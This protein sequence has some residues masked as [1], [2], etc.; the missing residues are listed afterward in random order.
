MIKKK[1]EWDDF[2]PN[3]DPDTTINDG[4]RRVTKSSYSKYF[5]K[6]CLFNLITQSSIYIPKATDSMKFL[7]E[8]TSFSSCSSTE[9]GGCILYDGLK[10][11]FSQNKI[12]SYKAEAPKDGVY[13]LVYHSML[14]KN[15]IFDSSISYSGY[16]SNIGDFNLCFRG[17]SNISNINISKSK[18]YYRCLMGNWGIMNESF[19]SYS[20]FWN[21]TMTKSDNSNQELTSI[22]SYTYTYPPAFLKFCNFLSNIGSTTSGLIGFTLVNATISDSSF[23]GNTQISYIFG[24][25]SSYLILDSCY[26]DTKITYIGDI[27]IRNPVPDQSSA[28]VSHIS[29]FQCEAAIIPLP[30]YRKAFKESEIGFY[31]IITSDIAQYFIQMGSSFD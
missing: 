22:W 29:T 5:V 27:E 26:V 23:I 30:V 16:N 20:T 24:T 3:Q 18:M 15:I 17:D 31:F 7:T 4:S 25:G 9:N 6:L 10:G 12:C 13:C 14:Y 19:F 1:K 11:Q 2:Y 28:K 8:D 21:S